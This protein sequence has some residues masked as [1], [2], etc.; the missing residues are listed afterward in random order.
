MAQCEAKLTS[1]NKDHFLAASRVTGTANTGAQAGAGQVAKPAPAAASKEV[2]PTSDVDLKSSAADTARGTQLAKAAP[3]VSP[4]EQACCQ[5]KRSVCFDEPDFTGPQ[6]QEKFDMCISHNVC[7]LECGT[8]VAAGAAAASLAPA[9]V[10]APRGATTLEA[11]RLALEG[12]SGGNTNVASA[13]PRHQGHEQEEVIHLPTVSDGERSCCQRKQSACNDDSSFTVAVCLTKYGVCL[14]KAAA[15][16]TCSDRSGSE[17][18]ERQ[19]GEDT[20]L[21]AKAKQQQEVDVALP[22]VAVCERTCCQRKETAC[23]KGDA[24]T[25]SQCQTKFGVCLS[26]LEKCSMSSGLPS[27]LTLVLRSTVGSPSGSWKVPSA[28]C[29]SAC[30]MPMPQMQLRIRAQMSVVI[31]ASCP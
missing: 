4:C 28:A 21:Q 6:C 12:Q 19:A 15:G 7:A 16:S 14:S 18:A 2:A 23:Y 13:A 26:Q 25:A 1:C 3:A 20:A 9:G 8:S 10:A 17:S 31:F 11:F 5:R 22:E 27:K 24:F 29:N 30:F